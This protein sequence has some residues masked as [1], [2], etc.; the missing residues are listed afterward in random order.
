MKKVVVLL[1][2][3]VVALFAACKSSD[4]QAEAVVE[5]APVV[6]DTVAV[7]ADS[8]AVVADS[9]AADSTAVVAE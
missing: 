8:A 3:A 5:D 2:F 6:A 9:A 7:V 1:S 4:S